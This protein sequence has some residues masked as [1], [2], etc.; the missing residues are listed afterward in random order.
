MSDEE[1]Q[2]LF[3]RI[4]EIIDDI[5]NNSVSTKTERML[6]NEKARLEKKLGIPR[7]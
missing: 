4:H 1:K 5:N 3:D 7:Q 6:Q 2:K